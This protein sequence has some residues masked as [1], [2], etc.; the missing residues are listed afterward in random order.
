MIFDDA[1]Y[2]AP[3]I[4]YRRLILLAFDDALRPNCSFL[5]EDI[6]HDFALYCAEAL[7]PDIDNIS[8]AIMHVDD[9]CIAPPKTIICT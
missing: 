2:F 4:H 6:R 7:M 3:Q 5:R 8:S 9:V 1:G